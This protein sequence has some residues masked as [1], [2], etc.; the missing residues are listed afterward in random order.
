MKIKAGLWVVVADGKRGLI[1][2][3]EG[4]A[5]NPDLKTLRVYEQEN[6]KTSEQGRDKPPRAFQSVGERRS[7]M[8]TTDLHRKAEDKFVDQIINDLSKDA[9]ANT[10][11]SIVIIAPPTAIGEMRKH[12]KH[13]A[14]NKRI[15]AWIDKDLTHHSIPDI[16]V[17]VAKALES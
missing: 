5:L 8:A 1:L 2:V 7:S 3:N 6:P 14:L 11:E 12:S 17:A 10:F 13:D 9:S 4:N 15:I 16:T